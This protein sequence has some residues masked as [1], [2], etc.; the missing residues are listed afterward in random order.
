VFIHNASLSVN[1]E[2]HRNPSVRYE[3]GWNVFA[4]Q[5]NRKLKPFLRY[6]FLYE[7]FVFERTIDE[8]DIFFL[9]GFVQALNVR[10]LGR[11]RRTPGG[12]KVEE[13]DFPSKL[14]EIDF[15]AI[16]P[17]KL[18]LVVCAGLDLNA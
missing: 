14:R 2:S 3:N 4:V 5:V 6:E 9:H 17:A 7:G 11:A 12:P 18:P 10:Q 1:Y 15:S 13:Y 16:Q 8:D